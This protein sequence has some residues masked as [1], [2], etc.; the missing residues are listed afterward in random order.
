MQWIDAEGMDD[1]QL[2]ELLDV[3]QIQCEAYA[4]SV[5]APVPLNYR[6]AQLLQA[7]ALW[8]SV[9]SDPNGQLDAGGYTVQVYPMDRN[10]K[11]LLRPATGIPVFGS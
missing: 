8:Q 11:A 5:T 9:V 6:M 2:Q 1:D 10:V 7:R 4:P 3:A